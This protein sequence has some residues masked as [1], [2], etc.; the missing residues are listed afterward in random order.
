MQNLTK[1]KMKFGKETHKGIT[2][3]TM[4]SKLNR[5]ERRTRSFGMLGLGASTISKKR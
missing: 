5:Y 3:R 4:D 1:K 2:L